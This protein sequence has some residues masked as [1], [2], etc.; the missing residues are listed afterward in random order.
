MQ[1]LRRGVAA[2][3]RTRVALFPV[4]AAAR[5]RERRAAPVWPAG[6]RKTKRVRAV[7]EGVAP[8]VVDARQVPDEP[9]S[10]RSQR[11]GVVQRGRGRCP[12]RT[13]E[14]RKAGRVRLHG[15]DVVAAH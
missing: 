7:R 14:A 1:L 9:R 11:E 8:A 13:V 6:P 15:P 5:E 3:R 2:G 4:R 12:G 10:V